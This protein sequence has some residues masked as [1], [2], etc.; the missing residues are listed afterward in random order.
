M[1]ARDEEDLY[2]RNSFQSSALQVALT[3]TSLSRQEQKGRCS[4][5]LLA[6]MTAKVCTQ[7]STSS[8]LLQLHPSVRE[9]HQSN[10]DAMLCIPEV[11][12]TL[13]FLGL[14]GTSRSLSW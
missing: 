1:T 12:D 8:L 5:M 10:L 6:T 14:L 3:I 11:M 2:F 4:S 13:R 7:R 9:S